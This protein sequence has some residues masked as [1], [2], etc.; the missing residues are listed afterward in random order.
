[1]YSVNRNRQPQLIELVY[2]NDNLTWH[3][4][5]IPEDEIWVKVGGDKG[6][7]SF[8]MNFQICNVVNPNSKHNT[9][10]FMLFM[11]S[12]SVSNLHVGLDR[13]KEQIEQLQTQKWR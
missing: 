5:I 11:A 9:C 3:D 8:K 12:D 1:M 10:I 13:Y 7:G 4:G 2:S 6:G